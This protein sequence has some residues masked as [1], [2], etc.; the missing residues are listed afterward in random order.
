MRT[1]SEFLMVD[2]GYGDYE[3]WKSFISGETEYSGMGGQSTDLKRNGDIITISIDY[4]DELEFDYSAQFLLKIIEEWIVIFKEQRESVFELAIDW[5]NKTFSFTRLENWVDQRKAEK[6]TYMN[7][8][9]ERM[10][11]KCNMPKKEN[12]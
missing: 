4:N 10:R 9:V 12:L 7:G 3:H 2:V 6:N 5:D 11:I 1:L 8:V